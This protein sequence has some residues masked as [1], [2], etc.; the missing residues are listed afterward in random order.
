M[1][2]NINEASL[3]VTSS[4][5]GKDGKI[6]YKDG[7]EEVI[8]F[9]KTDAGN[10]AHSE[11]IV[12]VILPESVTAI[13]NEYLTG[14]FAGCKALKEVVMP[15][16]VESIENWA[17][18][19]CESLTD[20]VI[21]E[22]VTS[23]GDFAFAGCVS[24]ASVK[25]PAS[26]KIIGTAAFACCTSLFDDVVHFHVAGHVAVNAA[27]H[28]QV[29]H[30]EEALQSQHRVQSG[31]AVTLGHDK[32]VTIGLAGI[33]DIHVHHIKVQSGQHV[34]AGQRAA[35][36]AGSC[37][38]NHFHS[39]QTGLGSVQCKG[40]AFGLIHN[41]HILPLLVFAFVCVCFQSK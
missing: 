39:R 33:V 12:K 37:T 32:S 29:F 36:M 20:I 14:V 2:E 19:D 17:F 31:R 38:V 24:L 7:R 34:Q 3:G 16:G 4:P 23:I 1:A 35:G 18:S 10:F 26:V 5:V 30:R 15:S 8:P 9:G 25:I 27:E 6:V 21:P 11:D 28:L 22:G 41:I 40:L 13:K